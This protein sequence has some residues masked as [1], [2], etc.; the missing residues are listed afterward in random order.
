MWKNFNFLSRKQINKYG[1]ELTK[2]VRFYAE[3][4]VKDVKNSHIELYLYLYENIFQKKNKYYLGLPV[5]SGVY[6]TSVFTNYLKKYGAGGVKAHFESLPKS[7]YLYFVVAGNKIDVYSVSVKIFK[8]LVGRLLNVLINYA[9]FAV[10][11]DVE[12]APLNI[13]RFLQD[14]HRQSAKALANKQTL[15]L[16]D[17]DGT[18]LNADGSIAEDIKAQVLNDKKNIYGLVSARPFAFVKKYAELLNINYY[19]SE[20]G[21][22]V[23]IDGSLIKLAPKEN[24]NYLVDDYVKRTGAE[25]YDVITNNEKYVNVRLKLPGSVKRQDIL[26]N[27]LFTAQGTQALFSFVDKSDAVRLFVRHLKITNDKVVFFGDSINDYKTLETYKNSILMLKHHAY[28]D[29]LKNRQ[30]VRVADYFVEKP[31]DVKVYDSTRSGSCITLDDELALDYGRSV[32]KP[33]KLKYVFFSHEHADHVAGYIKQKDKL[34]LSDNSALIMKT[35]VAEHRDETVVNYALNFKNQKISYNTDNSNLKNIILA[36]KLEKTIYTYT[37]LKKNMIK[38]IHFFNYYFFDCAYDTETAD[39]K[40]KSGHLSVDE[41]KVLLDFLD[42]LMQKHVDKLLSDKPVIYLVHAT[43]NE[44]FREK[45]LAF[46]KN[47]Q[48]FTVKVAS[49]LLEKNKIKRRCK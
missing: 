27:Y 32:K 24:L 40:L 17:L 11:G 34:N 12:D 19:A 3:N 42:E 47:Y 31:L 45:S 48:H 44:N 25:I 4:D 39:E 6:E 41:I 38:D 28:C 9:G 10:P 37:D 16:F 2:L 20:N 46:V 29:K 30:I 23:V 18:I 43:F 8:Q 14:K 35:K 22:Q 49:K 13:Q 15:Y 36:Y 26:K 33:E 21:A 1:T 7:N 5:K